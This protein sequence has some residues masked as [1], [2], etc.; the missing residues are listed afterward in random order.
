MASYQLRQR[1]PLLDS[2][3]QAALERRG[4]ELLGAGLIVLGIAFVLMLASY[5]PEDPSWF[6]A[7]DAPVQNIMGRL[8]AS[9]ASPL[10]VI[11]G[12]GG[13]GIAAVFLAWGARFVSHR[14]EERIVGRVIFAPIGIALISVYASTLLETPSWSHSFGLG[15]LFGDAFSGAIL[16]IVQDW[17]G[18]ALW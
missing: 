5:S 7:T 17:G 2:N 14:G 1:D 16:S 12:W 10:Y 15:G 13:W 3:T 11:I 9:I 6:S 4:K 18:V 8:G